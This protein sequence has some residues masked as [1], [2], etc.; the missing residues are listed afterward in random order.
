MIDADDLHWL[1]DEDRVQMMLLADS[2]TMKLIAAINSMSFDERLA[3]VFYDIFRVPLDEVA[4]IVEQPV[5]ATPGLVARARAQITKTYAN[6]SER[7]S[8]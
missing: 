5:T 8:E 6:D 2:A 7:T 3:F 4:A 1:T